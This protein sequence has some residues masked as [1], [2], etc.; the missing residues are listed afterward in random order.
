MAIGSNAYAGGKNERLTLH[1]PDGWPIFLLAGDEYRGH[2]RDRQRRQ[3]ARCET[4]LHGRFSY[5]FGG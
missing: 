5:F 1:D 2:N 3:H 4:L